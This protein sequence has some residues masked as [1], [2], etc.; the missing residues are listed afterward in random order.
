MSLNT[1]ETWFLWLM[2]Y[3]IL[4]WIYESSLCSVSGKKFINR[5]FLNGPY[6]PIYGYGALLVILILGR[7][8]NPVVL[9]VLGAL[10]T[11]SLE[12]FTSY[13]MEKLFHARWWDYTNRRFNIN[14]RICLIG[15]IVFG[16]FSVFLV[17]ILQPIIVSFTDLFSPVAKH[18]ITIVLFVVFAT[19]CAVTIS[20][21]AGFHKKLEELSVF[22]EQQKSAA[23]D[24]IN[25]LES[26][27]QQKER[28]LALK[29]KLN[30]Q[31]RRM[32]AAFPAFK[33]HKPHYNKTLEKLRIALKNAK[34]TYKP[35]SD[36]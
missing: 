14:G 20:G 24:Y 30:L 33:M 5:G 10:V 1:I 7:I 29:K 25:S 26:N 35:N 36:K 9:F 27:M 23:T 13:L 21:F 15:A 6:C 3:S 2:I 8:K 18:I 17:L 28:R 22:F 16:A 32:L 12:Y 19:D 31:Q 4:G 34:K 11:C